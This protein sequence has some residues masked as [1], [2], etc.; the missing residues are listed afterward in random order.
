MIFELACDFE[1][2][3][4][5]PQRDC[6]RIIFSKSEELMALLDNSWAQRLASEHQAI[7]KEY[8]FDDL[9]SDPAALC[10]QLREAGHSDTEAS[11]LADGQFPPPLDA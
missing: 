2:D 6:R 3:H 1:L 5:Q 9:A 7:L 11:R 4:R 10:R 8:P